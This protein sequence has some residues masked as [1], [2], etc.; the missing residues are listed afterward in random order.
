M[1]LELMQIRRTLDNEQK[2]GGKPNRRKL[3]FLLVVQSQSTKA[4]SFILSSFSENSSITPTYPALPS[5]DWS[6]LEPSVQVLAS[7]G[8][9]SSFQPNGFLN[10]TPWRAALEHLSSKGARDA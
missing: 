9:G 7:L 2:Q 5:N 8:R 10:V 4:I 6:S 3:L 1:I